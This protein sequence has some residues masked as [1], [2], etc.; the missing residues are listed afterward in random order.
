MAG[1]TLP[2][3]FTCE[4]G[5]LPGGIIQRSN[6]TK[7]GFQT[8]G[9]LGEESNLVFQFRTDGRKPCAKIVGRG[10]EIILGWVGYGGMVCVI[11]MTMRG[12]LAQGLANADE[13]LLALVRKG[14]VSP[15]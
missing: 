1:E 11:N 2:V 10:Q 13:D 7:I 5:E 6:L 4:S 14:H 8:N 9:I 3:I 15:P 12:G